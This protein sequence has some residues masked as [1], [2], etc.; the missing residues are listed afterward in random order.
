MDQINEAITKE[1]EALSR[2]LVFRHVQPCG[3]E[4]CVTLQSVKERI[5]NRLDKIRREHE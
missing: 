5:E 4:E 3:C 2:S 1:L